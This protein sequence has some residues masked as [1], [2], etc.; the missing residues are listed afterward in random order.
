MSSVVLLLGGR[1]RTIANIRTLPA[2]VEAECGF[3]LATVDV[4]ADVFV[5]NS[6]LILCFIFSR[7]L[8]AKSD[9][10]FQSLKVSCTDCE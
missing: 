6:D 7:S 5:C 10:L 4:V 3:V 9:L 8:S 1:T 2:S